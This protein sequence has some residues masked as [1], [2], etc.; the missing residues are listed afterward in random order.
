MFTK[1]SH[2]LSFSLYLP[3]VRVG[4]HIA[5]VSTFFS[6]SIYKRTI[7]YLIFFYKFNFCRWEFQLSR[8]EVNIILLSTEYFLCS[9]MGNYP[10]PHFLFFAECSVSSR[11]WLH[12]AKFLRIY[13]PVS[14]NSP[15]I[16]FKHYFSSPPLSSAFSEYPV[17]VSW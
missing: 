8:V 1:L 9:T 10:F 6:F 11:G 4:V 14:I 7:F 13:I 15:D 17:G 12:Y 5:L 3:L 16:L 2:T